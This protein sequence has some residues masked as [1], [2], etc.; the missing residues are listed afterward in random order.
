MNLLVGL[1]SKLPKAKEESLGV[2]IRYSVRSLLF[3][4][5]GI[6]MS[7]LEVL[8]GGV[9]NTTWEWKQDGTIFECS[10]NDDF[11]ANSIVWSNT[12]SWSTDEIRGPNP[13]DIQGIPEVILQPGNWTTVLYPGNGRGGVNYNVF[14]SSAP[15]PVLL[16]TLEINQLTVSSSFQLGFRGQLT[17]ANGLITNT[18]TISLKDTTGSSGLFNSDT[19][20]LRFS[21]DAQLM[22][23]TSGEIQFASPNFNAI[24]STAPGTGITLTIDGNQSIVTTPGGNN[25]QIGIDLINNGLIHADNGTITISSS[26]ATNNSTIKATNGGDLDLTGNVD[27]TNG[28]IAVDA[29]STGEFVNGTISGGNLTIAGSVFFNGSTIS[30]LPINGGGTVTIF[31]A[32][33]FNS[34][35][36]DLGTVNVSRSLTVSGNTDSNAT[37]NLIS[38]SLLISGNVE[39]SGNG[40][41]EATTQSGN[42]ISGMGG[43]PNQLT[44]GSGQI[45]TT[46]PGG[47]AAGGNRADIGVD[48]INNGLIDSNDG[49]ILISSSSATNNG[50]IGDEWRRSRS[51]RKRRQFQRSNHGRCDEHGRI[52]KWDHFGGQPDHRGVRIFQ[53]LD[54]FRSAY[55]RGRHCYNIQCLYVQQ[56]GS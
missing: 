56:R 3:G 9:V 19:S 6:T 11:P 13:C 45:I 16:E 38:D 7:N 28:Q 31:N 12:A 54:N 34:V 32:S 26:S 27:N 55:Q 2:C 30:D 24:D 52:C 5:I 51:D 14:I 50:T 37:I 33:T 48:L 41:I 39:L 47:V 44:L 4:S 20:R 35:D 29:T 49:T 43:G 15:E 42:G 40:K 36:L 8:A 53:W 46:T 22:G 23:A 25:G 10:E 17:V 18:G 1:V 21:A